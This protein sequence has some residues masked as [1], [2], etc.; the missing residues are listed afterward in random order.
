M[1]TSRNALVQLVERQT[2]GGVGFYLH[3]SLNGKRIRKR[4]E[5]IPLVPI[6]DKFAYKQAKI[7]A[8]SIQWATMEQIHK[9][10]LGFSTDSDMLLSDWF[11]IV[12]EKVQRRERK[13]QSR[14]T[15]ARTIEYT[16][17]ILN[18]FAPNI[19]LSSIDKRFV[20]S[21]IDYLR[22]GYT[23]TR[24]GKDT[25]LKPNSAHKKYK[26]F[27]F[28]MKEAVKD[29]LISH[30]P[31]DDIDKADK[32][33]QETDTREYLTQEELQRLAK[34]DMIDPDTKAAYFFMC[35]CGLRI[36]DVQKL[37][38]GDVKE[39]QGTTIL[40]IT[41][42]KTQKPLLLPLSD[43]A[44]HYLPPRQNKR[45]NERIFELPAEATMNKRLKLWA[46]SAKVNKTVTL[47]TAR[48]TFATLMLTKGADVYTVSKL[49]GHSDIAT[50]Q[51][52]AKI[53]DK[54]KIEAVNLLN[55]IK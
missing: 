53:I 35:F 40:H 47:H 5:E 11:K 46:I 30:N 55:D 52:Y 15:W 9:G 27:N 49:L 39:E 24:G 45:L 26:C 37:T 33:K 34:S 13:D 25:T 51:V 20:L 50:T 17:T 21:V 2:S 28:A 54:K 12:V 10:Q 36:S 23:I 3:Y 48:H 44:R 32:I 1:N 19:K 14:H 8:Q 31:C 7:K 22:N 4:I 42:Q 41:M 6:S 29:G 38:W 43:A 16:G 18:D